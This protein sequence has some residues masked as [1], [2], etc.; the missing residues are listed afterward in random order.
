MKGLFSVALALT[1]VFALGGCGTSQVA[2][3]TESE[4]VSTSSDTYTMDDN[5]ALNEYFNRQPIQDF[6]QMMDLIDEAFESAQSGD[7]VQTQEISDQIQA[8]ADDVINMQDVPATADEI[9]SYYVDAAWKAKRVSLNFVLLALGDDTDEVFDELSSDIQAMTEDFNT[10][11][12]LT[13]E[14][15]DSL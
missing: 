13:N 6:Y 3:T 11:N 2:E 5:L 9:H 8:M 7:Y 1:I 10:I 12:S 4:I 15:I 14:R